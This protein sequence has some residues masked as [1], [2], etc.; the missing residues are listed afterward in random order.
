[1]AKK[2]PPFV[3]FRRSPDAPAGFSLGDY[4]GKWVA[5]KD[6]PALPGD[7]PSNATGFPTGR[8]EVNERGQAAEVYEVKPA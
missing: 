2:L 8:F 4:E 1:M 3:V 5:T 7:M 6:V